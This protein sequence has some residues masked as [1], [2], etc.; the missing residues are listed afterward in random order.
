MTEVAP[1]VVKFFA[2]E[3]P[4]PV[5]PD[6]WEDVLERAGAGRQLRRGP[7][8]L[9]TRRRLVA[10]AVTA[11]LAALLV[12][13]ALGIGDRL[14]DLIEGGPTVPDVQSPVWSPDGRRIAF[15]RR[16]PTFDLYVMHADGSG[17]LRLTRGAK[18][19]GAV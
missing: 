16:S 4:T 17:V 12:A 3:Y 6:D 5:M 7:E 15:F 19:S 14:L 9:L 11:L 1:D 13:P 8:R 2:R 10:I 18:G